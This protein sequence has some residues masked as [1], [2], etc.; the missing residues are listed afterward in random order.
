MIDR[1]WVTREQGLIGKPKERSFDYQAFVPDPLMGRTFTFTGGCT[2]D[3]AEAEAAIRGL[4]SNAVVLDRTDGLARLLLRAEAQASSR[5]EGLVVG[6]H[7]LLHA[8]AARDLETGEAPDS[9]ADEVLANIDAMNLAMELADLESTVTLD[10]ILRIHERVLQSSDLKDH[11]GKVRIGQSWIGG[12]AYH[13]GDAAFVPPPPEEVPA[14]LTDL[15]AFC[16][17]TSLPAVAQAAIAHAQFETIH[18]FVDGN[19]RTGRA[20]THVMLRRRG[21]APSWCPPVSLVLAT[22]KDEYIKSLDRFHS[23]LPN[24]HPEAVQGVDEWVSFFARACTRSVQD[25]MQ[26]EDRVGALQEEWRQR[27][28]PV[29]R[30]SSVDLLIDAL[31]RTVILTVNE[32]A[33]ILGRSFTAANAAIDELVKAKVLRQVSIGKRNRAFESPEVIAAFTQLERRLASPAGDTHT[34]APARPV[35]WKKK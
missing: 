14:L 2:A 35:P 22:M 19:G 29:R 24:D 30:G 31:P 8:E 5:I 33:R 25:A 21:L 20:I 9:L 1:Q 11:G 26:F 15:A 7:K 16:N 6:A 34:A 28:A 12:N 32:A 10:T 23:E 18:P 17:D 4:A 27:L 3:I 13:P